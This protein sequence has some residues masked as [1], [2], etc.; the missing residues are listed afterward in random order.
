MLR[1]KMAMLF[2]VTVPLVPAICPTCRERLSGIVLEHH[3]KETK[4]CDEID[5]NEEEKEKGGHAEW[6]LITPEHLSR[7]RPR[8]ETSDKPPDDIPVR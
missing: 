1:Y 3:A 7:L 8:P 2:T 5:H 4:N 6:K